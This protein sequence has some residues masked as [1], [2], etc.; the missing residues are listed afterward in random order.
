M[1]P[2]ISCV[3]HSLEV[4]LGVPP[5]AN[6]GCLAFRA[7]V[8]PPA[9]W[10]QAPARRPR[11]RLPRSRRRLRPTHRPPPA[12]QPRSDHDGAWSGTASL[13]GISLDAAIPAPRRMTGVVPL[14]V[15]GTAGLRASVCDRRPFRSSGVSRRR[16]ALRHPSAAAD[17]H[18][19]DPMR[20]RLPFGLPARARDPVVEANAGRIRLV[21]RGGDKFHEK[22]CS[23]RLLG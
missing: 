12:A 3:E 2:W 6:L 18:H 7:W 8:V 10:R 9:G 21:T 11:H 23:V 22:T 17:R 5:D 16:L 14:R 20:A 13:F 1:G 4:L 19:A 15:T